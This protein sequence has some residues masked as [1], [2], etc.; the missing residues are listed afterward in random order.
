MSD[1]DGCPV[2]EVVSASFYLA[3]AT[4]PCPGCRHRTPVFAIVLPQADGDGPP[5]GGCGTH[6]LGW[7]NFLFNVAELAT[8]AQATLAELA[9]TYRPGRGDTAG[10]TQWVNACTTCGFLIEDEGLHGEPGGAFLPASAAQAASIELRAI[11][12]PICAIASCSFQDPAAMRHMKI[13]TGE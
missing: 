3:C 7:A 6:S 11:A 4:V 12:Q 10:S 5:G 2:D 8:G 1:D 9:S 13:C